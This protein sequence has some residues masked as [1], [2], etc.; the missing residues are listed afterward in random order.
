MTRRLKMFLLE[1]NEI[2]LRSLRHQ[3]ET[4]GFDVSCYVT[5]TE[6]REALA[7]GTRPDILVMDVMVPLAPL[8]KE[9]YEAATARAGEEPE[10]AMTAGLRIVEDIKVRGLY[11]SVEGVPIVFYT[12]LDQPEYRRRA[13]NLGATYVVKG[14]DDVSMLRSVVRRLVERG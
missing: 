3:F 4:D 2:L 5:E 1:D 11:S 8:T 12:I 13:E 7:E 6:F 10:P 9:A 14:G